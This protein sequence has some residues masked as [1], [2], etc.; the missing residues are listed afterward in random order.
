MRGRQQW[1]A[2]GFS[3]AVAIAVPMVEAP[4]ALAGKA[5]HQ[6]KVS[7][8]EARRHALEK[9]P[10]KVIAEELEKEHGRWI[11]SFEIEA[12]G[13]KADEIKEVNI[14]ADSGEVV[15]I[16]TEKKAKKGVHDHAADGD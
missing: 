16:E 4:V 2:L 14:D 15:A 3:L 7:L 10:G 6:A 5:S 1:M 8:E 12:D 13:G 11:Y 9:V